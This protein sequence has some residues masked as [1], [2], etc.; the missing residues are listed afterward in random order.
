M[1]YRFKDKLVD[2]PLA[3]RGSVNLAGRGKGGIAEKNIINL[4]KTYYPKFDMRFG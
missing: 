2:A 1:K 4:L 3:Y